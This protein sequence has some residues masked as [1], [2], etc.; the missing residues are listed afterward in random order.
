M[1]TKKNPID[2][3]ID[4]TTLV[5]APSVI[6]PSDAMESYICQTRKIHKSCIWKLRILKALGFFILLL[7]ILMAKSGESRAEIQ[8]NIADEILRFHVLANSDSKEDQA[9]KLKVKNQ[10]VLYMQEILKQCN[11]KQEAKRLLKDNTGRIL[12]IAEQVI[13]EEG[14]DYGVTARLENTYF[15]VKTYGE[16]VF[17]EGVYEAYRILIGNAEGKNWWCVMFPSLCMVNETYSVV[18]DESKIKL[19]E[20]L[21]EE[22]YDS[23]DME[24]SKPSKEPQPTKKAEQKEEPEV[25]YHFWLI[26]WVSNLF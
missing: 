13:K 22:E 5:T 19:K 24:T 25:E 20:V 21:T 14:Y 4:A 9:L 23:I 2:I 26:D 10:V 17:P 7:A 18:P 11:S 16:F 1:Y 6:L 3:N 15:P 8:H 12:Q